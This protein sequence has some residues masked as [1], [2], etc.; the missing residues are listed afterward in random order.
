MG[1]AVSGASVSGAWFRWNRAHGMA[2]CSECEA[3]ID[4]DEFDV[5][6]GDPL[7]CFECGASLM[8]SGLSPIALALADEE[9]ASDVDDLADE[10]RDDDGNGPGQ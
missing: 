9:S 2:I 1:G 4:V 5:G 3:D 6:R 8:V 10:N 7:S